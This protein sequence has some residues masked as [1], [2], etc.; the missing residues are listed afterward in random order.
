MRSLS[1][2]LL[3]AALTAC[4]AY[5]PDL[6]GAPFLCAA[7][8]PRCPEGYSCQDD[9]T[10]RMVCFSD[11][12]G[13][14]DAA[15]TGFQC[16][17]D[18]ILEGAGKNDTIQTAYATPVATQRKDISFAGLAICPEGDKDNYAVTISSANANKAIEVVVSWDSGQ[19]ISMSLLNAGGTSIGN[20]TANGDKS[21][22]V[23][24]ANMPMGTYYAS[25]FATG[26]TKNNYRLSV[27]V[28][29]NCALLVYR[30][31]VVL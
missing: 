22:R 2:L 9:G 16:A 26:S 3:S 15:P 6:G 23:C 1:F 25:V 28:L 14:V 27:K 29:A 18:S 11:S 13:V 7:D 30:K 10:S 8:E 31:C 17:D 24:V 12:G 20:G 19:P 4:N 21:L 5:N